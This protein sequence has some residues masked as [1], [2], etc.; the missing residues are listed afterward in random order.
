MLNSLEVVE[1]TK[2][3]A[4]THGVTYAIFNGC[5]HIA[6]DIVNISSKNVPRDA[7]VVDHELAR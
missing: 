1:T 6:C 3:G 7:N 2:N 5:Y 4:T